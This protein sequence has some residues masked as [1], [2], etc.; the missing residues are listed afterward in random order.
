MVA[1]G[2]SDIISQ[3]P[4]FNFGTQHKFLGINNLLEYAITPLEELISLG[5]VTDARSSHQLFDYP[6]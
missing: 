6:V 1:H 3:S 4:F 2:S 5:H